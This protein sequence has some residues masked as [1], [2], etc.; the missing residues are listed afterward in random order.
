MASHLPLR[1]RRTSPS[2]GHRAIPRG[3]MISI[4]P[5]RLLTSSALAL[6]VSCAHLRNSPPQKIEFHEPLVIQAGPKEDLD[7]ADHLK[8]LAQRGIV[9]LEDGDPASAERTLRVAVAAYEEAKERERLDDYFPGQA[10]FY[11]GE[12]YRSYYQAIKLDPST[13]DEKALQ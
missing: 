10:Q 13:S 1:V 3:G 2:H 7:P 4:C 5:R 8:A 11:L 12:V 6:L 9:E